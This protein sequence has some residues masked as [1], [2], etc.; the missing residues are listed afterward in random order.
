MAAPTSLP[1]TEEEE[2]NRL[3]AQEPLALL[4]GM[5]LDQQV[6]MEW[7][8]AGPYHLRERLGGRL[9][10]VAIAAMD[11]AELEDA[12]KRKPAL[13]R[14]P[15]NMAKRTRALCVYLAEEYGGD[16]AR[17][18]SGVES[19]RELYERVAALPGFGEYKARIFV[20]VLGKRL[21]VTP[22][23]WQEEA[24]TQPSIADVDSWDKVAWVREQKRAMKAA[25][26]KG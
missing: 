1:W 26:K 23:G 21:G 11:P 7:A 13:H 10:A 4:I 6:P 16:A 25:K 22:A 19:G 20:G 18:W 9:D 24:A 5:L 2:A 14:Y 12:F 17:L 8:F 3:L 15:A